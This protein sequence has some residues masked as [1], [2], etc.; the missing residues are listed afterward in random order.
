MRFS[1]GDKLGP[2]E[3]L[4]PLGAGGM[5]EVYR[6]SDTRLGRVVAIKTSKTEFSER[7][8]REAHAVAAL[9]HPNICTLHDVGP[10]YLVMEFIEGIPLKG[11][12]PLDRALQYAAQICD[13]LDTAH[14]KGITHRDLKPGNILVTKTG[15]K[16][17]DFGLAR[18][19]Q[20]AKPLDDA[21]LTTAL[22]GKHEI[23]G[24]LPYMSP[25]QLQAQANG[26]AIDARSDIF[27]F[28]LVLYEMLTGKRAIEGSSP[29]SVIAAILE[30]PAPSIAGVAPAALDR[31]FQRCLKKDPDDRW[32]SARDVK[33]ALECVMVSG[34]AADSTVKPKRGFRT[35][36]I[37]LAVAVAAA[38]AA[39]IAGRQTVSLDPPRYQRLTFQRGSI[40]SARFAPEGR[41][42]VYAAAWE[43]K[44]YDLFTARI[45]GR[46]ARALGIHNASIESISSAGEMALLVCKLEA[47]KLCDR[48]GSWVLA[49]ASLA[50]GAP[51]E[52][53]DHATGA[54]WSPDGSELAVA[55]S[56]NGKQR[57]EYPLGKILYETEGS[58]AGPWIS[59][60]GVVA[61]GERP[62]G[63]GVGNFTLFT[64]DRKGERHAFS[65]GWRAE[66]LIGCW[67]SS[68]ELVVEMV[69]GE[70]KELYAVTL[71]GKSRL[72]AR[73]PENIQLA[74]VTPDGRT[75]VKF[76][77][78]RTSI[79]GV[80]PGEERERDFSLLDRSE[81]D[82]ISPDGKTLLFT[83]FGAGGGFNRW[84]VYLRKVDGN[85]VRLG[86]GQACAL[87]PDGGRALTIR[88]GARQSIA[89]LPT[90][91]GEPLVLENPDL[92]A[93]AA[94]GWLPS[95]Q[96]IVFAGS[97]NEPG[98]GL[99]LYVQNLAGKPRPFSPTGIGTDYGQGLTSPDGRT[100][101][102]LGPDGR[103]TLYPLDGDA[104]VRLPGTE[105]GDLP[106]HW[107]PDGK[108]LF[109]SRHTKVM[110]VEL[111]N[112]RVSLW[113]EVFPVDPAGISL[114]YGFRV[115]ADGKSYFYNYT[116]Y[117][118]DLYLVEGLK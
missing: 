35:A 97:S 30:R 18:M 82:D 71:S 84:S 87:S 116:R 22:T 88:M 37:T 19:A 52:I 114:I 108:Y 32:Q 46:E 112:G 48:A 75:L 74:D 58:L 92:S 76:K 10:N 15:I 43:G 11:P 64:I 41:T 79:A 25:E 14:R 109:Y 51:R 53:V 9:N 50:G 61:F 91:A 31:V 62:P 17:L 115:A 96:D 83:E 38:I 89:I 111:S 4:E 113:K 70:G 78:G 77:N 67:A 39:F 72:F 44:P 93:Y 65:T 101:V 23:V 3:I 104:A 28:G 98:A 24:T 33:T 57:I 106:M 103:P 105:P 68:R 47:W 99:R 110:K 81:V 2:Y 90:G 16:L 85:A 55:R 102:V 34:P 69:G 86:E 95:G 26:Q 107:T 59:S 42:I 49:R 94:A 117:L 1:A 27:S 56:L 54:D 100:A 5:G 7:F 80:P 21:T 12:L 13:A 45:D 73:F 63:L 40:G 29:A 118:D 6:A 8:E 60:E 66:S 20:A 36:G